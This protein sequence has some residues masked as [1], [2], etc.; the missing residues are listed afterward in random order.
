MNTD[1][2]EVHGYVKNMRA[3]AQGGFMELIV[4]DGDKN[5]TKYLFQVPAEWLRWL[6]RDVA[7]GR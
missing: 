1:I 2:P 3:S 7:E 6:A 5:P 4:E